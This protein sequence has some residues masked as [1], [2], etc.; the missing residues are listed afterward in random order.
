MEQESNVNIEENGK[1]DKSE[2]WKLLKIK[3]LIIITAGVSI[4]HFV[5]IY[6]DYDGPSF[7]FLFWPLMIMW[8]AVLFGPIAS[9]VDEKIKQSHIDAVI[10]FIRSGEPKGFNFEVLMNY[11]SN[12]TINGLVI[13]LAIYANQSWHLLFAILI[14][15]IALF[16][17]L[18][19]ILNF[20]YNTGLDTSKKR[21]IFL[22]GGISV[23]S[24]I[25]PLIL[26]N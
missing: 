6:N 13:A 16:N 1:D 26:A 4:F 17:M 18:F 19:I 2:L 15:L 20:F 25:I 24:F 5:Q 23:L 22:F 11:I 7:L 14:W 8:A 21:S 10:R 3:F 12:L 9:K